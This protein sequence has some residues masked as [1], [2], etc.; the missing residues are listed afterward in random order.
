MRG[1]LV[2]TLVWTGALKFT[3]SEGFP[4]SPSSMSRLNLGG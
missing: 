2:T 1:G 4:D 3:D